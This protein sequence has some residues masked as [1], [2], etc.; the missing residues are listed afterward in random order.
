[1][2]HLYAQG[3]FKKDGKVYTAE[4]LGLDRL[5]IFE[6]NYGAVENKQRKYDVIC[7]E[8]GETFDYIDDLDK[9]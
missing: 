8:K 5:E 4:D 3:K 9:K 2:L 1:V 6:K 7:N